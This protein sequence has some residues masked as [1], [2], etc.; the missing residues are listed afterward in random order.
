MLKDFEPIL[1]TI[2]LSCEWGL[3]IQIR[4]DWVG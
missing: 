2:S 1:L 3:K 4:M